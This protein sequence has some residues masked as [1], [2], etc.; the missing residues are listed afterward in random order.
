MTEHWGSCEGLYGLEL[1]DEELVFR[2]GGGARWEEEEE[3]EEECNGF[4][5]S[6]CTILNMD[7]WLSLCVLVG[8][9]VACC[10]AYDG[11]RRQA[12]SCPVR[13]FGVYS[14]RIC[15]VQ[16][17]WELCCCMRKRGMH[18]ILEVCR[19]WSEVECVM[20]VFTWTVFV[21]R[22][23]VCVWV[24]GWGWVSGQTLLTISVNEAETLYPFI[25]LFPSVILQ[26]W[27]L[28]TDFNSLSPNKWMKRQTDHLACGTF[29][30]V[31]SQWSSV[32]Q[33]RG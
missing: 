20:S 25:Q 31:W 5:S 16:E 19:V 30:H 28:F 13:K 33:S 10:L 32:V 11:K 1:Q 24:G 2:T 7:N 23:G 26:L 15:S 18:I 3:E 22:G 12:P 8:L 21:G 29:P 14:T 4:W 9:Q 27:C 6:S 17:F